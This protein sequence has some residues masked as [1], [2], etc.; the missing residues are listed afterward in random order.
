MNDIFKMIKPLEDSGV[1]LDGVTETVKDEL[2]TTRWISWNI[3]ST[4]SGFFGTTSNLFSSKR[5]K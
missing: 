4:F 5:Y 1:L 2:K 3:V